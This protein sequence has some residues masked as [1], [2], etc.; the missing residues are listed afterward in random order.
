MQILLTRKSELTTFLVTFCCGA[1]LV[2]LKES[3]PHAFCHHSL[4]MSIKLVSM[5]SSP[6]VE[7]TDL[8]V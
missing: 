6:Q 7:T 3:H 8:Q 2:L 5:L 4:D 1:L